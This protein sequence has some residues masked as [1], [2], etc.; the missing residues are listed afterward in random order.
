MK[1]PLRAIVDAMLA[2]QGWNT[3]Y[4]NAVHFEVV[5]PD[6]ARADYVLSDVRKFFG[7]ALDFAQRGD[8]HDAAKAM[9]GFGGAGVLEVVEVGWGW[10]LR[11]LAAL[12]PPNLLLARG[13]LGGRMRECAKNA[14][15]R[16]RV[17]GLS[18]RNM[19][20]SALPKRQQPNPE[21]TTIAYFVSH[22]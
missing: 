3:S 16:R 22:Y 13:R 11:F 6:G 4:P 12:A 19:N 18:V 9:K 15:F 2:A 21:A 7:H 8:Q 14:S 17:S 20:K 1:P 10:V 5:M